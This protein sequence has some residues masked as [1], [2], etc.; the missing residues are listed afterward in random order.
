MVTDFI[1]EHH[2]GRARS[3]YALV[4]RDG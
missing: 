4:P 2:E 3:F 1:A